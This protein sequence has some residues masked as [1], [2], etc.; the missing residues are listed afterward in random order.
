MFKFFVLLISSQLVRPYYSAKHAHNVLEH[1]HL[2][3]PTHRPVSQLTA[4]KL[5]LSLSPNDSVAAVTI[6]NE[7]ILCAFSR[8]GTRIRAIYCERSF[9]KLALRR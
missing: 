6:E 8:N 2:P 1:A 5:P 3:P 7:A 9:P 4:L